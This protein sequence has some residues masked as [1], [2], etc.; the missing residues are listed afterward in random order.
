MTAANK[1]IGK[2]WAERSTMGGFSLLGF[3][4]GR[5]SN[6]ELYFLTSPKY[7]QSSAVVGGRNT[8]SQPS[9]ILGRWLQPLKKNTNRIKG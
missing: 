4:S 7:F 1:C 9:P 6:A 5:T 3:S 2:S 8:I